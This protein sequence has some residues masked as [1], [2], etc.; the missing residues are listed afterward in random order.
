MSQLKAHYSW[1]KNDT[2]QG[3]HFVSTGAYVP[4]MN[5]YMV[6]GLSMQYK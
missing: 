4:V 1:I 3:C 6:L 2:L 5:D